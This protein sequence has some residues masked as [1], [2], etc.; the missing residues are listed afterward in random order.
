[1]DDGNYP[2]FQGNA[3]GVNGLNPFFI[4]QYTSTDERKI[5]LAQ[6]FN[7]NYQ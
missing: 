4:N 7:L 2:A 6:S 3:T 1:M 5:D